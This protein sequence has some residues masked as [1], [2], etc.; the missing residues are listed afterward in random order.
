MWFWK[1]FVWIVSRKLPKHA[2]TPNSNWFPRKHDV[3][4]VL[5]KTTKIC[6]TVPQCGLT[7]ITSFHKMP[8]AGNENE[9]RDHEEWYFC[10]LFN[11][12][13]SNNVGS[14]MFNTVD[15]RTHKTVLNACESASTDMKELRL[16]VDVLEWDTWPPLL[17]CWVSRSESIESILGRDSSV[18]VI[19]EAVCRD[20]VTKVTKQCDYSEF[21][22]ISPKHDFL[23]DSGFFKK[24]NP[25]LTIGATV[26]LNSCYTIPAFV[27]IWL[28]GRAMTK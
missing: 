27:E 18:H 21:E 7:A 22:L 2:I 4:A 14:S 28:G 10:F 20:C 25:N 23:T 8:M 3:L 5:K 11:N 16:L 9:Q 12:V 24:N 1:R 15:T 26:W 13:G 19:L 6:P 17:T